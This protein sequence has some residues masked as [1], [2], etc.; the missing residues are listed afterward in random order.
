MLGTGPADKKVKYGRFD[1]RICENLTINAFRHRLS[2]I[3][4]LQEL[5]IW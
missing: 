4:D 3:R 5:E 2:S 1:W